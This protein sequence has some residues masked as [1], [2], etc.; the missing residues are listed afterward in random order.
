MVLRSSA[1]TPGS[2]PAAAPVSKPE[3]RACEKIAV[4]TG[5]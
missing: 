5:S 1:A 3:Q 4:E 2:D